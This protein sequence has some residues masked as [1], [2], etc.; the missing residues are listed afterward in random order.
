M[1]IQKNP[2]TQTLFVLVV[3][4]VLGVSSCK[5][6]NLDTTG[7]PYNPDKHIYGKVQFNQTEEYEVV[8]DPISGIFDTIAGTRRAAGSLSLPV[9]TKSLHSFENDHRFFI[10][11]EASLF[12]LF[13]Q[14]LESLAY[15]NIT[16]IDQDNPSKKVNSAQYLTFGAT[17][18]EIYLFD[19]DK[20]I[21]KINLQDGSAH[22][23]FTHEIFPDDFTPKAV[24]YVNQGDDLLFVQDASSSADVTKLILFDQ[25]SATILDQQ[26]ISGAFGFVKYPKEDRFYFLEIPDGTEGFR[27]MELKTSGETLNVQA[28]SD[29]DLPIDELSPYL[30]TIHTATNTYICRGGSNSIENSTNTLYSISLE[31]GA[32]T[33]EAVLYDSGILLN[34]A[35][36]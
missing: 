15:G 2:F 31:T 9:G 13:F 7:L 6:D 24:L 34:L 28:K 33:N 26:D 19:A 8:I 25:A 27:L 12:R 32:L 21:W 18:N 23:R 16:M 3:L 29:K 35:G 14:N 1:T 30:Q 10:D 17:E 5:K 22:Q 11:E 4:T 20:S 36:E